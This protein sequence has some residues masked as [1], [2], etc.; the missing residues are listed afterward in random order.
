MRDSFF[1]TSRRA[2]RWPWLLGLA[3]ASVGATGWLV[4]DVLERNDDFCNACH[5]PSGTPL[6]SE[7]RERFDARPR[8]NLA[9][10]HAAARP[11]RG[12]EQA[13]RCIDCHGGVGWVGRARVK[14]L[15]AKD[16]FW[17]AVGHFDEPV[18]M[19]W[20]LLDE[21]CSQCHPDFEE[22]RRLAAEAATPPFHALGVHN[23]ALGVA[24]VDCHAA[25]ETGGSEELY[26]LQPKRVRRECAR[27]HSEFE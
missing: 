12:S 22:S 25:H 5:L 2:R 3:V 27:C 26:H 13:F 4:S 6:H 24:C 16:G 20:P 10:L 14:L 18:E 7:I 11:T 19:A 1:V 15:A 23:V 21:D 17:Y 9:G 8:V